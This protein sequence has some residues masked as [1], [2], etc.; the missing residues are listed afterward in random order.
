MNTHMAEGG[1]PS[2]PTAQRPSDLGQV[3]LGRLHFLVSVRKSVF[4]EDE[5]TPGTGRGEEG[6]SDTFP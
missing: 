2:P 6:V 3:S 4:D 1:P 5:S